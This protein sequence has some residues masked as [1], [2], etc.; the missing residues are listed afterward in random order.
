LI[1]ACHISAERA[2]L[3]P[4][5]FREPGL[6]SK[7]SGASL[8]LVARGLMALLFTLYVN[9]IPFHLL[10]ERHL[11]DAFSAEQLVAVDLDDHGDADHDGHDGH[12]KPHPSSEHSIQILPKSDSLALCLAFLPAVTVIVLDVPESRVT[13]TFVERIWPPKE[14]PPES[15]QPRAPPIA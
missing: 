5:T 8:A 13:V 15:S 14:S 3:L 6:A 10:T 2:L 1:A 4:M 12:H 7:P 11:D 9:S